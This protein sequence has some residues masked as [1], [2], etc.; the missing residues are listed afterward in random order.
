M[1][2]H[3][4]AIVTATKTIRIFGGFQ[5]IGFPYPAA[6][7]RSNVGDSQL[8]PHVLAAETS[9][10]RSPRLP[11]GLWRSQNPMVRYSR[12]RRRDRQT[13]TKLFKF[14]AGKILP[15]KSDCELSIARRVMAQFISKTPYFEDFSRCRC[16][17]IRVH[18][19]L[20]FGRRIAECGRSRDFRVCQM[21]SY[22]NR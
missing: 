2:V 7:I 11:L 14:P 22:K 8:S 15:R 19:R 6:V 12:Y 1:G 20:E 5:L 4:A 3:P 10:Y 21:G 16:R 13:L 18:F 17:P 9:A